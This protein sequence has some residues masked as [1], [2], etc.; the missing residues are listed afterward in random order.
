MAHLPG[1]ARLGGLLVGLG[2]LGDSWAAWPPRPA[3]SGPAPGRNGK[4]S[5]AASPGFGT[6]WACRAWLAGLSAAASALA[7]LSAV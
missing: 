6:A 3:A 2:L 1:P 4:S 5:R 7:R